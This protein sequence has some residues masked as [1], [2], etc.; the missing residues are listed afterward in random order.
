[1]DDDDP[2]ARIRVHLRKELLEAGLDDRALAAALR[3]GTLVR[4][5]Y[6][7]YVTGSDWAGLGEHGRHRVLVRAAVRQ[8]RTPVVVS[9]GSAVAELGGPLWGLPTPIAQLTRLDQRAG[10]N[11]ADLHQH[12]G[13]LRPDDVVVRG[14]LSVTTPA[15]TVLDVLATTSVEVGLVV[16]NHFLHTRATDLEELETTR[17]F[18]EHRPGT[19]GARLVLRLCDPAVESVGES[20]STYAFWRGG[21]PAPRLQWF[22]VGDDGREVRLDFAWPELGV[23]AEFDGRV[24]YGRL[25][26]PG[27]D[28]ADVIDAEK[29]REEMICRI[30]GWRCLRILWEDLADPDR[31]AWRVRSL[32]A[33]HRPAA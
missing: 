6:G 11:A 17:A 4:V 15:V 20:R 19:L 18:H 23:F 31:L 9:H 8:S 16:A 3:D 14:G 29:R 32:A 25:L 28:V 30:T 12:R 10:R 24:K 22:L 1:M 5:R 26:R 7:A 2:V 27:Q 21:L 33:H 13:V